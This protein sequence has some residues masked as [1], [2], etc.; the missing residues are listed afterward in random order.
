MDIAL[1]TWSEI[2]SSYS[3]HIMAHA[4][5]DFQIIDMEHGI[6]SYETA[7][8]MCFAAH[9]EKKD[10]YLRVPAIDES[11]ILRALDMNIDGIIFPHVNSMDQINKI[12]SFCKFPPFG[13]RGFNPYITVGGYTGVPKDFFDKENSHV[14][15]GIILEDKSAFDN[16]D[17]LLSANLVDI[18]YIGQYDLSVSLNIPGEV[19]NPILI[20]MMKQIVTKIR[21][22]G[23]KAGCMVH[24]VDEAKIYIN[25]GFNFIV[26]KVDSGL[27]FSC[28]NDFVVGVTEK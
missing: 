8:N 7:E 14:K 18:F 23:K 3:T 24:S 2:P 13:D 12:K 10:I 27:L 6:I 25:F 15:I 28:I 11:Y 17:S 21:A 4:G 5:L 19:N 20:N 26:Y 1:G 22:K 16:I 9:S